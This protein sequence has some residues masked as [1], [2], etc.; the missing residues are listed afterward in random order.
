MPKINPEII[1]WARETAGLSL[2]DAARAIGL[3][4]QQPSERLAE[5]ERGEREPTRR[6]LGEM[7]RKYRRPLLTFYLPA[8]PQPGRPTHDFRTLPER[9]AGGEAVLDAILRDVKARQ[10]IVVGALEDSDHLEPLPFV[11]AA[12]LQDGSGDLAKRME[13]VLRFTRAEFRAARNVTEAFKALRDACEAAG[14]YVIL[15]GNLGSFHSALSPKVFRGFAMAD[16]FAPFIV[17]NENDARSAWA[18]T[19]LHELAHILLGASGISGYGS[20]EALERTCDA[21]AAQF[22]VTDNELRGLAGH[23]RNPAELKAAIGDF[24][25]VRK[26]SRTML[27]YNLWRVGVIPWALFQDL[28]A[29]FTAERE[30]AKE[31]RAKG[32]VDYY[33]VRRHRIG[34]ALIH[35]VN[36]MVADGVLSSI[37]AGRVLGVKPTAVGRMTEGAA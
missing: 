13:G 31:D 11:G 20:D 37:S 8:R 28:A 6:Q 15:M 35:F 14:V 3:S 25:N 34:R 2:E 26:V 32:Q 1:T 33:V 27:A 4:G 19:L 10:A 7:A 30:E 21:A 29:A 12:N 16:E 18:F 36:R 23:A 17:I 22:L 24:A 5:I 9:E